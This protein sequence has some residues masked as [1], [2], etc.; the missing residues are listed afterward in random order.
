MER[1]IRKKLTASAYCLPAVGHGLL[2]G[3]LENL[4][5]SIPVGQESDQGTTWLKCTSSAAEPEFLSGLY[6]K[7]FILWRIIH[8]IGM[9][10]NKYVNNEL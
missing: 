3:L 8:K 1:Q 4:D 10:R 5:I 6:S 9:L 2:I 7:A